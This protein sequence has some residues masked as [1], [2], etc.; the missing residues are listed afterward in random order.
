MRLFGSLFLLLFVSVIA[1]WFLG[2]TPQQVLDSIS[3]G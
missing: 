2:I 3:G 1:A